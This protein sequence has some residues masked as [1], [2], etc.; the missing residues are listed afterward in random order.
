MNQRCPGGDARGVRSDLPLQFCGKSSAATGVWPATDLCRHTSPGCLPRCPP[1]RQDQSVCP[2]V[3]SDTVG[4]CAE[5]CTDDG[6]CTEDQKCCSNGC[7]HACVDAVR[8]PRYEWFHKCVEPCTDIVRRINRPLIGAYVPQCEAD[9]SFS[10]VQA[11]GSTGL[12]WCVDRESG[13]AVSD[14][15][16]PGQMAVCPDDGECAVSPYVA[17]T[18]SFCSFS[19]P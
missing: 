12:S 7:G 6:D 14:A 2:A 10:R 15:F 4:L 17:C 8:L 19:F 13:R 5:L 9:G 3:D 16:R 18:V 1:L 11:W